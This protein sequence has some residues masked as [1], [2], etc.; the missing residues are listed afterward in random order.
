M[1][2]ERH[3]TPA[4]ERGKE[5]LENW[6]LWSR[7]DSSDTGYPSRCSYWTPPRAGDVF[8]EVR[9]EPK[10]DINYRDAEI[11]E[12][13]VVRLGA[14]VTIA[15]KMRYLK[16]AKTSQIARELGQTFQGAVDMLNRAEMEVGRG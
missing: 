1:K 6:A 5:R 8:E 10:P 7:L 15:V 2:P 14:H 13:M 12:A 16:R 4:Q 11:V 3:F 9:D